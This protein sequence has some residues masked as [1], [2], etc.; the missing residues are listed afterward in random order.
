MAAPPWIEALQ[1]LRGSFSEYRKSVEPSPG[2]AGTRRSAELAAALSDAAG[3][4][5]VTAEPPGRFAMAGLPPLLQAGATAASTGRAL[6]FAEHL[7][8]S[9]A[10][11]AAADVLDIAIHRCERHR[12]GQLA[13]CDSSAASAALVLLAV[14]GAALGQVMESVRAGFAPQPRGGGNRGGGGG[15]SDAG[16]VGS[17]LLQQLSAPKVTAA[18]ARGIR[19]VRPA[20]ATVA[21]SAP[22]GGAHGRRRASP[23][24][25]AASVDAAAVAT[26]PLYCDEGILANAGN[27]A[28]FLYELCCCAHQSHAAAAMGGSSDSRAAECLAAG[29]TRSGLLEACCDLAL[30]LPPAP[31]PGTATATA[32]GATHGSSAALVDI[33]PRDAVREYM[34]TVANS[35]SHLSFLTR[36]AHPDLMRAKGRPPWLAANQA[37]LRAAGKAAGASSPPPSPAAA[38]AAAAVAAAASER[39]AGLMLAPPVRA[40]QWALLERFVRDYGGGGVGSGGGVGDGCYR[41]PLLEG[42]GLEQHLAPQLASAPGAAAGDRINV[43]SL[44]LVMPALVGWRLVQ[45]LPIPRPARAAGAAGGGGGAAAAIAAADGGGNPPPHL[46]IEE[47]DAVARAMRAL[48]AA[49]RDQRGTGPRVWLDLALVRLAGTLVSSAFMAFISSLRLNAAPRA[50]GEQREQEV[51]EEEKDE[52]LDG[53]VVTLVGAAACVLQAAAAVAEERRRALAG[54]EAR[55]AAGAA[56][57]E[58]AGDLRQGMALLIA[59]IRMMANMAD[60]GCGGGKPRD[61][62]ALAAALL[63]AGWLPTLNHALRLLAACDLRSASGST[64]GGGGGGGGGGASPSAIDAAGGSS[65]DELVCLALK[66]PAPHELLRATA[67]AAAGAGTAT[68][69][70]GGVTG[71]PSV[72]SAAREAASLMLTLAKLVT[73]SGGDLEEALAAAETAEAAEADASADGGGSAGGGSRVEAGRRVESA[74]ARTEN[75]TALNTGCVVSLGAAMDWAVA[76]GGRSGPAAAA[77]RQQEPPPSPAPSQAAEDPMVHAFAELRGA[78]AVAMRASVRVAPAQMA[79][80]ARQRRRPGAAVGP[81]TADVGGIAPLAVSGRERHLMRSALALLEGPMAEWVPTAAGLAAAR[82]AEML[83]ASCRLVV[84]MDRRLPPPGAMASDDGDGDDDGDDDGGGGSGGGGGATEVVQCGEAV[85]AAV[86][87]M[88][89]RDGHCGQSKTKAKTLHAKLEAA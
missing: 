43:A 73:W 39:L 77:A 31:A 4:L 27:A 81:S 33:E 49:A 50:E 79:A 76:A 64:S 69:D 6:V 53:W 20:C 14:A 2:A 52:D 37:Q 56:L 66:L 13:A 9:S 85:M 89:G 38:G 62:G 36:V 74:S 25:S 26:V 47:V 32:P 70:D 18:V 68:E 7:L 34:V 8:N 55:G 10:V 48:A 1:R 23:G 40:L 86:L 51:G 12:G 28:R 54:A 45:D 5:M 75:A 22:R 57:A 59:V 83:R 11:G 46:R 71:T 17:R 24:G 3:L 19:Q 82:P 30:A 29:L 21:A 35:L 42:L 15:G 44:T 63:R 41:G 65:S 61:S 60:A 67:T 16:S 72:A 78:L 87:A 80:E 84:E 88:A 58:A